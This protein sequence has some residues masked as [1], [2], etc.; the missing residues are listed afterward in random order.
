MTGSTYGSPIFARFVSENP[1]RSYKSIGFG[2]VS[3]GSVAA[4]AARLVHPLA[5][6]VDN[7]V[8]RGAL[9]GA[10]QCG[11]TGFKIFARLTGAHT[12]PA[13]LRPLSTGVLRQAA[14]MISISY[15]RVGL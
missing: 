4:S 2:A 6:V 7:P 9:E 11:G 15:F 1:V 14:E 8:G 3:Q 10:V 5:G 13:A 12:V